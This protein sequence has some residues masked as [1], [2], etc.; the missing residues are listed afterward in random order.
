METESILQRVGQLLREADDLV[1]RRDFVTARR[2][3]QEAIVIAREQDH[4]DSLAAAYYGLAS[5][6]WNSG[7][8]SAEAH[9]FASIAA[10]NTRAN[11][12]T[13]LLLRT[14]IARIKAARGNYEA[15]ILLNEDVL[16][17]YHANDDLRGQADILRS[18][19][20]VY[21]TKGEFDKAEDRYYAALRVYE[22]FEADPLNHAALLMSLG[23]LKF[24]KNERENA[25]LY[26]QQA[27]SIAEAN[28]FRNILESIDEAMRLFNE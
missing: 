21:R 16:K 10:Q 2:K 6:V 15:A 23:S 8:D 25:R 7:G 20:D 17:F 27:R 14:L 4:R 11:T 5:V 12:Q 1:M 13:D 26:W 22:Q 19:G 28:G 3:T 9:N 18:L 24:Q